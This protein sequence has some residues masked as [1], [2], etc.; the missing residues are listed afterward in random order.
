MAGEIK[1][2]VTVEGITQYQLENGMQVLLFPDDS[3]PTVTVSLTVF[4]GSR[5][6]GYG[7]AGMAHLL[8]HM[9]F[10]GTPT[11]S[12]VPKALQDRGAQFNGTTWVDRTNYYET[13]PATSDNLEFAIKLEADRMI[14]SYIKG[15]DLASEMTV[16]RNEFERGENSPFRVLM[17][18]ITSASYDWHNYGQSTIGNRSDIERVPLPNLRSFYRRY[19][20]PDNAMLVIAGRFDAEAALK[21]TNQNFGAI[22][23]PERKLNKTYTT[24]PAQDGERSVTLRRVGDVGLVGAAYHIPAGPH[25]D[26]ASVRVLSY[27]LAMEPAGR[28]YKGMVETKKAAS[29]AGFAYPFHDPGLLMALAEV[30]D[31]DKIE[32][33]HDEM[34]D[35]LESIND[36]QITDEEVARA[37]LAILK[38]WERSMAE[39][40]QL[41]VALSNWA[42]QGDWRLFFLYRDRVEKVTATEVNR[43]AKKYLTRNNRTSGVYIP[44]AKANRSEIP[45]TPNVIDLVKDYKGREAVAEGEKFDASPENIETRTERGQLASGIGYA[46]LP[47]K[48]RGETVHV[49]LTLRYGNAESLQ[50]KNTVADL[51]PTL[52]IRGS[53][54]LDHQQLKDALDQNKATLS[55]T[56]NRGSATFQIQTKRANLPNVL[57]ILCQVLREPRLDPE[58]LEVVRRE[59]LAS[60]EQY[61]NDPRTLASN[62]MRRA[63]SPYDKSDVRYTPTIAEEIARLKAV[64]NDQLKGLYSDFLSGKNGQLA[65]VGDFD[66][67]QVKPTLNKIFDDWTTE[68]PY[69]RIA[70]KLF[71]EVEGGKRQVLTPDKANASYYAGLMLPLKDS[72]AVYPRLLIGNFVLGGGSLSSRLGDRVRQKEGLS[73]GVGSGFSASAFDPVARLTI[74]AIANPENTPKLVSVIDEEVTRW[75]NDGITEEELRRAKQG[76]LQSQ[77][78]SRTNDGRLAGTLAGTLYSKRTMEYYSNLESQIEDLKLEEVNAALKKYFSPGQLVIVTAGDFEKKKEKKD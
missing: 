45:E 38:G 29:V 47:K 31:D 56:G 19:Y 74:G 43:A 65:I 1:K 10:K 72:D 41:A 18:R 73:Y 49:R 42:A 22:P 77:Q 13:L 3:K 28:L 17:Q 12:N 26:F 48:T 7:E 23:A 66:A 30:T 15:E 60:L 75:V 58:A 24:E 21:L 59:Q 14:N 37:K 2:I 27:A 64:T 63:L 35:I 11:H 25:H 62:E 40:G 55:A 69:V 71:T 9:L 6:E 46:L 67:D 78:V 57:D 5:H 4:V 50:G 70:E 20:Q 76:Y 8:E 53:K 39:S 44:T 34:I 61:L 54:D 36:N 51:L 68:K 32:E 52:M 16:V 33:V